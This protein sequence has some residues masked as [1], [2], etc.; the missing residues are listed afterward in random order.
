M[1]NKKL[2]GNETLFEHLGLIN[3]H[4]SNAKFNILI[5]VLNSDVVLE[6]FD[7]LKCI[8]INVLS[9]IL[10]YKLI[11]LVCLLNQ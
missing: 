3:Q 7:Q 5:A 6:T 11:S 10:G 1:K 2:K 4:N 9:G 8:F